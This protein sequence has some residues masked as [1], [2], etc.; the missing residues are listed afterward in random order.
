MISRLRQHTIERKREK[1]RV[2][3]VVELV[4]VK[5]KKLACSVKEIGHDDIMNLENLKMRKIRDV[6]INRALS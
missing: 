5:R 6:R 2:F 3:A 4:V 1:E